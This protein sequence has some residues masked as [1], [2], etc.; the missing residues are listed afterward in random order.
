MA[1]D[2]A[3]MGASDIGVLIAYC[4]VLA[5]LHN[6]HENW[7][8]VLISQYFFLLMHPHWDHAEFSIR[9][10][11]LMWMVLFPELYVS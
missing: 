2:A 8:D 10:H 6:I 1:Q 11:S 5:F 7:A 3:V 4:N 9:S